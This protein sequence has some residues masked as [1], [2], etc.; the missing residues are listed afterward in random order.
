MA[1]PDFQRTMLPF[2]R[3]LEAG[4]TK[5]MNE[6]IENLA[7]YFDLTDK[8]R[9]LMFPSG[10]DIIYKNRIRFARMHLI[11]AGL[12]SSPERGYIQITELG[13]KVLRENPAAIDLKFLDQFPSYQNFKRDLKRK[14]KEKRTNVTEKSNSNDLEIAPENTINE[15]T[16]ET[17]ENAYEKLKDQSISDILE[18]V[19]N[20]SWSFFEKL[21][22]DL[23]VKMGYGGSRK[24]AG[25][26]F[27]KAND[28]GIDG[29]IKEDKLGLDIIY[30]QAK[31]WKNVV[32]RP[33]IQKFAGALQGKRARKG[34]FIT[35]SRFTKNAQDYVGLIDSKIVLI[36][37]DELASLMLDYNLGVTVSATYEL[38]EIDSDY[39]LEA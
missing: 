6:V 5:S 21:V 18:K 32:G 33:E 16:Q 8:E 20:C 28:E 10:N 35:T 38:K 25:Q 1:I 24:D 29:I 19:E 9:K 11:K 34:V 2:L 15:T 31:R 39:F 3:E 13:K 12:I 22:V 23:L 14:Q 7:D 36:D 37:G 30:V 27:A 4:T 17:L 26:A